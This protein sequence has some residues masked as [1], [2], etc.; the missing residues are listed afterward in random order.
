MTLAQIPEIGFFVQNSRIGVK[1]SKLRSSR[2]G[3]LCGDIGNF[4]NHDANLHNFWNSQCFSKKKNEFSQS[5]FQNFTCLQFH[6]IEISRSQNFTVRL[7]QFFTLLQIL[8]IFWQFH[9]FKHSQ[10]HDFTI[11][12]RNFISQLCF[13]EWFLSHILTLEPVF[14][15]KLKSVVIFT[16]EPTSNLSK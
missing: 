3:N 12:F 13:H 1:D 7:S 16:D 4:H 8:T 2:L 14:N 11:L 15:L 10:F 9:N 5:Q 6:N